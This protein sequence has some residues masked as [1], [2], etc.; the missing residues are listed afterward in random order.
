[1]E[2][3]LIFFMCTLK[4]I[5][6]YVSC[7]SL[8]LYPKKMSQTVMRNKIQEDTFKASLPPSPYTPSGAASFI[9]QKKISLLART[10]YVPHHRLHKNNFSVRGRAHI[11]YS[12]IGGEGSLQMITVLHR[13]G[14]AK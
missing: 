8:L 4:M 13:G 14:L 10:R 9:L 7:M 3:P 1:M 5:E 11:T 6:L 2:G 12:R